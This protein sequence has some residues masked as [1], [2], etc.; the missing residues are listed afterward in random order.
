MVA[1]ETRID[2]FVFDLLGQVVAHVGYLLLY[3][4]LKETGQTR[5]HLVL[6]VVVPRLDPNAVVRSRRLEVLGQIVDDNRARQVASQVSQ[7][8]TVCQKG[9]GR[10]R[11][12][13][14]QWDLHCVV[15]RRGRVLS[16]QTV[17]DHESILIE[18]VHDFVR[19]LETDRHKLAGWEGELPRA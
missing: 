15:F 5:Q 12:A 9:H 11:Q 8:F 17:L 19:I 10:V 4:L 7:V 1:L 2:N 16:V 3:E 13:R 18:V 6:H 14:K